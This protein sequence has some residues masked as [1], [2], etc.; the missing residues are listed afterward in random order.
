M[1]I[2]VYCSS[3]VKVAPENL[4]LGFDLG[5]AIASAGHELVWGGGKISVMGTV[6]QGARS[7]GGK[8]IGVIPD[9][10][11]DIEF[12]DNESH[13]I[14]VVEDMRER[15]GKIEELSD[16]FLVLPGGIG[17]LEE[18]FEIWVGRYLGF[19]EKPIAVIDPFGSYGSLQVA[20]NDL[21]QNHFMKPG[22]HDKVLWSKSIDDALLYITK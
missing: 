19:H 3:S 16:A 21:T 2:A 4:K 13:E 14:L 15:K 11:M 10:L 5:V 17:T 8:T 18:F 12:I 9:R 1:R 7:V 20:L 6:A 22:Q